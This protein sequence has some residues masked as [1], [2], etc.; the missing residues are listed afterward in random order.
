MLSEIVLAEVIGTVFYTF[1]GLGLLALC[2]VLIEQMTPF[3]L[4][5]EIEEDQNI[6]VAVLI[7]ALFVSLS[8]IVAA[9]ILS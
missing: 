8:I 2:W 4:R 9:V 6:A 5:K 3:S 1:L 7:A